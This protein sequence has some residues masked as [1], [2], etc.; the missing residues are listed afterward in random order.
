MNAIKASRDYVTKMIDDTPGMKILLLDQETTSVVSLVY[1]QTEILQK[2]V[3]LTERLEVQT[4]EAMPNLKA[5][6]FIRP[7][8]ESIN[9]LKKEL[10]SPKYSEYHIYFSNILN[11][12]AER[13]K[14]TLD[15]LDQLAE[16]DSREVV[17]SV[18]EFFADYFCVDPHLVT[19]NLVG[20]IGESVNKWRLPVFERSLQGVVSLLLS[21]K[22]K[23]ALRYQQSSSLCR[24]F[25][26]GILHVMTQETSLFEFKREDVEPILL[27]IDRRDDPVTPMLNQWT[28]QAMV[29]ELLKVS[30]ARVDLSHVPGQH[31]E[32]KEVVLSAE[33]DE[34]YAANMFLNYGEIGT[35]IKELVDAFQSEK[36]K[37]EKIE[38][39][40]D[41]KGFL[42]NYPQ[43]REMSGKV[44]KHVSVLAELQRIVS[45]NDLMTCS[46]LEQELACK[47]NHAEIAGKLREIFEKPNLAAA[48]KLRLIML[49]TLRYEVYS[50]NCV[51]EFMDLLNPTF[52]EED[53]KIFD[54]LLKYA[55]KDAPGRSSDLY[56]IKGPQR[57]LKIIKSSFKDVENV[58][59]EHNPLLVQTL[60]QLVKGKLDAKAFPCMPAQAPISKDKPQNVF[61]FM[62]G[63]TTFEES[64]CVAK[65]NVENPATHVIL[66][67]TCVHNFNSF[68][69]EIKAALPAL[70]AAR[71]KAP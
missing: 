58:Y 56:G 18:H 53:R 45:A 15:Y 52:G 14:G 67:S 8:Q 39:I 19:L 36:K 69:E 27:I 40:K 4:R 65:F 30:N 57:L 29:H 10:S 1:S 44:S 46:E 25:A 11:T 6:V 51:S 13:E 37:H 22:Q 71:S 12:K 55:G 49:Y 63:G 66:A 42:D 26:E 2:E 68:Q 41:M 38:S 59:T 31:A 62:V 17:K 3:Y 61:I 5:V 64:K 32:L 35:H 24:Q 20:C 23:P 21:L 48:C 54:S 33:Q 50:G 70:A 7:V 43:F 34:F 47:D 9:A 16:A 28:Y 60:E